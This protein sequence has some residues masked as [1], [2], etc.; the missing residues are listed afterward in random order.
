MKLLT[1]AETE[2]L[3]AILM[4]LIDLCK[5]V[6]K[7]NNDTY[8]GYKFFISRVVRFPSVLMLGIN[9]GGS[10]KYKYKYKSEV[11]PSDDGDW[12]KKVIRQEKSDKF[13]TMF[14]RCF[15]KD[16]WK[17]IAVDPA[18]KNL[19]PDFVWTN[20]CP[21]RTAKAIH[22]R[23]L[24]DKQ[25]TGRS[26]SIIHKVIGEM[27]QF[28][29]PKLIICASKETMQ[30]LKKCKGF[31]KLKLVHISQGIYEGSIEEKDIKVLSFS[32]LFSNFRYKT[33][34]KDMKRLT[35]E[36]LRPKDKL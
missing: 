15:P 29:H 20:I 25:G 12:I 14:C 19:P 21:I 11:Y 4:P 5:Q 27:I 36:I 3:N 26:W 13:L 10:T 33:E 2:E 30:E 31:G 1:D 23:K 17:E 18:G 16:L 24:L 22:Y 9:P 34:E 8:L 7:D 32:R 35:S 6:E 28:I